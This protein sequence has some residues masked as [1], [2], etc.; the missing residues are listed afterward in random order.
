M[1]NVIRNLPAMISA[2][3]ITISREAFLALEDA[4]RAVKA[5][6]YIDLPHAAAV[7][8]YNCGLLVP[9]RSCTGRAT[10]ELTTKAYGSFEL[11]TLE[12]QTWGIEPRDA[13][14]CYLRPIECAWIDRNHWDACLPYQ[15]IP[16]DLG[17][18][19][20]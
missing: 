5:D 6:L 3:G 15:E 12:G 9:A 7:N 10:W 11:A 19:E 13:H 8:L 20:G 4:F 16:V 1:T 14:E 17:E 2:M 18:G